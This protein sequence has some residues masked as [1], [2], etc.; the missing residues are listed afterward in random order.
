MDKEIITFADN[1][2]KNVNFTAMKIQFADID[3]N[4]LISD[5]VS[6][7]EKNYR[8]FIGYMDDGWL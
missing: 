5:K 1:K 7:G 6:S 4:R 2:F 3:N 8:S